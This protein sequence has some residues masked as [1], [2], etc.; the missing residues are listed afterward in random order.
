MLPSVSRAVSAGCWVLLCAFPALADGFPDCPAVFEALDGIAT[1]YSAD[2]SGNCSFAPTGD[3]MV[4][5]VAAP[6]WSN[7]A[8]CGRCLEVW[9]P[10][11]EIVVRVV[12]QCPECAAGHI[13][14]SAEAFAQIAEPEQGIVPVSFRSIPCP[15]TG[16]V[17]IHQKDGVNIWWFAIQVR[18]HRY[19]IAEVELKENNSSLWQPMARQSYNYF[20]LT[21]GPGLQFPVTLRIT[22]VHQ[23]RILETLG[24]VVEDS[25]TAGAHQFAPCA[26]LFDDGFE[27]GSASPWWSHLEP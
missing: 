19:G 16:N 24:S 11:G 10:L 17:R 15:V 27:A 12:D 3:L 6:D 23:Q 20:L 7:S 8:Q 1:Y 2:G 13:D 25:D 9:G 14:L 21:S 5:A 4:T 18:N 22:D 26:G